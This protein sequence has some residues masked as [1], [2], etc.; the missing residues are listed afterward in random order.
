MTNELLQ[1]QIDELRKELSELYNDVADNEDNISEI[2][3]RKTRKSMFAKKIMRLSMVQDVDKII[4]DELVY[5]GKD[6][7]IKCVC[8]KMTDIA[9]IYYNCVTENIIPIGEKC[10]RNYGVNVVGYDVGKIINS[11]PLKHTSIDSSC[12]M[13]QK[14]ITLKQQNCSISEK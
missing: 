7:D 6:I 9:H 13:L 2:N 1:T 10:A 14:R 11:F 8:G 12:T 5:L 4:S 3:E